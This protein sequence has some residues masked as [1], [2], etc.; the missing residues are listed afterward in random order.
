[1]LEFKSSADLFDA[2]YAVPTYNI[3]TNTNNW[4]FKGE[5]FTTPRILCVEHVNVNGSTVPVYPMTN[6]EKY[7]A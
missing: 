7:H 4:Q 1:M 5:S 3:H 2:G 6:L